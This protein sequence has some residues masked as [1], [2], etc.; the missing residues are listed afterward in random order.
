MKALLKKVC[1]TKEKVEREDRREELER[2][3]SMVRGELVKNGISFNETDNCMEL[4]TPSDI[5]IQKPSSTICSYVNYEYVL[6]FEDPQEKQILKN[7]IYAVEKDGTTWIEYRLHMIRLPKDWMEKDEVEVFVRVDSAVLGPIMKNVIEDI[8]R[9]TEDLEKV[10]TIRLPQWLIKKLRNMDTN[11]IRDTL[12]KLV[13]GYTM[14]SKT[15][16]SILRDNLESAKRKLSEVENELNDLRE[17]YNMIV[18]FIRE[19]GL[20]EEFKEFVKNEL[21]RESE[22]NIKERYSEVFEE[23]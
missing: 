21:E 3:L 13:E 16:L 7:N 4:A 15:D 10:Y 23:E 17:K 19:K 6:R 8:E 1:I 9:K 5:Q 22:E 2:Y 18:K 20:S 12:T 11:V 14:I